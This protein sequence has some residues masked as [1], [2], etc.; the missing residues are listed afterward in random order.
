MKT[1][2]APKMLIVTFIDVDICHRMT[3]FRMLYSYIFKVNILNFNIS[4][5]LRVSV[6]MRAM[7]F[8]EVDNYSLSNRTIANVV[9]RNLTY[10]SRSTIC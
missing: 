8:I 6:K 3:S 5:A 7:T 4:E 9:R 1:K 10:I 2:L